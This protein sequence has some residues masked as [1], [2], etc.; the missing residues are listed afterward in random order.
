MCKYSHDKK[1]FESAKLMLL[2]HLKFL[3]WLLIK[4]F[5]KIYTNIFLKKIK[6]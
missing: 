3:K 4:I 5:G 6:I 1:V 2:L